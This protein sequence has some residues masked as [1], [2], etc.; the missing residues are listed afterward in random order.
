[1]NILFVSPVGIIGGAERVLLECVR[2]VRTLRPTWSVTVLM[3]ADGPLREAV[4]DLDAQVRLVPLPSELAA[5]GDSRFVA[6]QRQIE[7]KTDDETNIDQ[8]RRV[9][10]F[11]RIRRFF[12]T[13]LSAAGFF[14]KLRKAIKQIR[15]D[16]IHSNGLKSHLC[17]AVIQPR[18]CPVLWH[19][20]DYYSHRPKIQRLVQLASRRAKGCFAISTS[21]QEDV[22]MVAPNLKSYLLENCVDT[23]YF[24]P[25]ESESEKLDK[26]AGFEYS[27]SVIR[28]GLVATYANWKGHDVFLKAISKIA[29]IRAYIVG[30]QLYTTSGSQWSEGELRQLGGDLG[31]K[32]RLGIVPFQADPRWIYRSLDIVVHASVRPEP[33]GLTIVE[34]MACGR[35]VVVSAAGGAANLFTDQFDAIAHEPGNVE[36]LAAAIN[37][38]VTDASLRQRIGSQARDTAVTRFSTA[39]FGETLVKTYE[40]VVTL[41]K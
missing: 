11:P 30:G 34:S 38:F 2:Q 8:T 27:D 25:G 13:K 40:Q 33:F 24:T 41:G 35:S 32:D 12:V 7:S 16:L 23:Q 14:L 1:M 19:I 15:P 9:S 22:Q 28:V 21:V 36:S 6:G 37:R 3:L 29:N 5:A 4:L 10:I 26:V 31:I 39:K 17:M 18:N 20:H